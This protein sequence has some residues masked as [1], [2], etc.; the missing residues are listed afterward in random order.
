MRVNRLSVKFGKYEALRD[1][2][3]EIDSKNLVALIGHNGAGK[4]TLLK[5][6]IGLVPVSS[7]E[8][9]VCDE[10]VA[11]PNPGEL[12][13]RGVVYL[14]QGGK[15]FGNLTV[16]ENLAVSGLSLSGA[17]FRQRL[18]QV[19]EL[20]PDLG[21]EWRRRAKSLS[22]G[23][24]QMLSLACALILGPRLL[25]LDEPSIGL[26]PAFVAKFFKYIVGMVKSGSLSAIIVEH[27]VREML[28]MA[29]RLYV[30]K[31]GAVEFCG[32]PAS[33]TENELRRLYF[34]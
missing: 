18:A 5:A 9:R 28:G 34:E 3:L 12:I 22:G 1:V 13:K 19:T 32:S 29:D 23:E 14:P 16:Y 31:R 15:V 7:G 10:L 6:I 33:V 17:V 24:R 4:T 2:S 21:G 26:S 8:V 27:N 25:L 30:L 20:I 11:S